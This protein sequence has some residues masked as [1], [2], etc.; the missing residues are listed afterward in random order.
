MRRSILV[1]PLLLVACGTGEQEG[2]ADQAVDLRV[3]EADPTAGAPEE[4]V[5]LALDAEGL[6][7]VDQQSGR[8]RL[9]A[10]GS[11]RDQ[12]EE[13]MAR[14]RPEVPDR[15]HNSECG[16]GPMDFTSYGP[17]RLHFQDDRLVGWSAGPGPSAEA[18]ATMDGIAVGSPRHEVEARRTLSMV[19][20]S[21]LGEEFVIAPGSG[22]AGIAGIFG[23]P[24]EEA[25]VEALWAGATCN[26]R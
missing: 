26:F 25:R 21:T 8:A 23:G 5:A 15:S 16:A 22:E 10:V 7:F 1:A 6:R 11:A 18:Y 14:A 3:A 9:L 24:G 13:A 17:F 20:G 2:A 19:E 12:A 4:A